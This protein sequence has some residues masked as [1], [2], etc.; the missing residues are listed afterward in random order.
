M[1]FSFL[2]IENSQ[3]LFQKVIS[4]WGSFDSFLFQS[5]ASI[6]SKWDRDSYLKVGQCLFHIGAIIPK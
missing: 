2:L 3:K 4:K 1:D 5:G 6:I